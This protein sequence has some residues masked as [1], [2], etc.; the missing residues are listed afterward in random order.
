MP[1]KKVGARAR[2]DNANINMRQESRSRQL[3][4]V[5][6]ELISV[7]DREQAKINQYNADRANYYPLTAEF[8]DKYPDFIKLL[9]GRKALPRGRKFFIKLPQD[10][11]R[12]QVIHFITG[13][14]KVSELPSEQNLA[15]RL[16]ALNQNARAPAALNHNAGAAVAG[17][18]A[19]APAALNHNAGVAVAGAGAPAALNHN[20]G[21]AVAVAGAGDGAP[22]D[23]SEYTIQVSLPDDLFTSFAALQVGGGRTRRKHRTRKTKHRTRKTK[24]RTRKTKRRV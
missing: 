12:D 17:A 21:A 7:P 6:I 3:N 10:A 24:H 1:P 11:R 20:A 2:P 4:T 19:G 23:E 22:D 14:Q 9:T 16:A 15:R 13:L 18:G 5:D 8:V